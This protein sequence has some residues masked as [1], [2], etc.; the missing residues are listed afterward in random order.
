MLSIILLSPTNQVLLLH[1]V[2]TSS[3]FPSA[4]VFPGGNL[5][6]FHETGVPEPGSPERHQDGLSYRLGAIR[7]TFEES[8]ILLARAGKSKKAPLLD[9]PIDAREQARKDIYENKIKFTDWLAS[10]GGVP[11]VG[12]CYYEV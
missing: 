8:G 4:H 3:A 11:D 1:R 5:S 9:V 7:E 6:S 2:Q 12:R 10:L